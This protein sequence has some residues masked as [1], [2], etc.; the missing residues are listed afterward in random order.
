MSCISIY[1]LIFDACIKASPSPSSCQH[2]PTTSLP[3][4]LC[5]TILTPHTL[6][7]YHPPNGCCICV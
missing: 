6:I 1:S 3:L 4:A 7:I 2:L 5:P